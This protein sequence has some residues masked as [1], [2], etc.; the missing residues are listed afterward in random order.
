MG[1]L[2]VFDRVSKTFDGKKPVVD[3]LDF[4]V[5]EGEFLTLLGPSGSGKTTTLMMLAGFESQTSGEIRLGPCRLDAI[6]SY[7]RDFGFVFQNYALFPHMTALQ[8]VVF[9]LTLRGRR[10]SEGEAEARR[11][12]ELVQLAHCEKRVPLHADTSGRRCQP[13]L[14]L[15]PGVD[16]SLPGESLRASRSSD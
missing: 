16:L 6:P 7:K 14:D 8:N 4:A 15:S 13:H 11:F 2:I 5:R 10:G 9:P 3:E 1:D 12:L